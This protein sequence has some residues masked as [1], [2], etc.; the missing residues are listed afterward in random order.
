[1]NIYNRSSIVDFYTKHADAKTPLEIWYE[2]VTK[3]T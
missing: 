2:E 3:K 1:M